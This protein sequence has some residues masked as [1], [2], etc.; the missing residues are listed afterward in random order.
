M[1]ER[2]RPDWDEFFMMSALLSAARSSCKH[3]QSGAVIAKDKR[4]IS[5]GYNGAPPGITNCLQQGCRKDREGISFQDKGKGVCR[6]IHAE[7]NAL[8]QIARK[9]LIGS[10]LYSVHLPCSSCAKFIVG[11]GIKE[12][13]YLRDYNESDI[14]TKE[15]FAEA[16]I[17]LKK[18]SLDLTKNL[19]IIKNILN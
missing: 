14:L 8:S 11:A 17:S 7:L 3:L 1:D 5:S 13:I 12:V 16:G 2:K 6:G 19:E 4:I 18:I 15:L 9:D 10:T